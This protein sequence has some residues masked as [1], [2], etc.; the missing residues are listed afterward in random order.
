MLDFDNEDNAVY[1]VCF[2]FPDVRADK[3]QGIKVL[4][5]ASE[6]R[7]SYDD[8]AKLAMYHAENPEEYD[9]EAEHI[10]LKDFV[11]ECCDNI[12]A[13]VNLLTAVAGSA[14]KAQEMFEQ[15]MYDISVKNAERGYYGEDDEPEDT[16]LPDMQQEA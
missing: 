15:G 9:E 5:E 12:Q 10:Y 6:C 14:K 4:E 7:Q 2:P 3:Q 1:I 16:E 11:M 13:T 8:L